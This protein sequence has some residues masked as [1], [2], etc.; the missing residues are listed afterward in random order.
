MWVTRRMRIWSLALLV[1]AAPAPVLKASEGGR[2]KV[3]V[4]VQDVEAIVKAVGGD[5]VD[6]FGLFTGCILRKDLQV[7]PQVRDRLSKADAVIWTGFFNES[8]A[9]YESVKVLDQTQATGRPLWVDVSRGA[10]R[11]HVPSS[12][13]DGYVEVSFMH[14]D[15]F[16]WLNP[17]NGAKIAANAAEGL[18]ELRPGKKDYFLKN[19][20][21]FQK[22][23]ETRIEKWQGEL[24]PLKGLRV[25]STQCGWQNF[26]QIGGPTFI[27][28]KQEPGTLPSTA[29]LVEYVK[30]AGV[31]V[32]LVDPNTPPEYGRAFREGTQAKVVEAPSSIE[33]IQ[34]ATAYFAL[35]ENLLSIL[36]EASKK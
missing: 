30:G 32:I 2:L 35:F 26:S 7:E 25:F 33:K 18:A 9:I 24:K 29:K 1:L 36:K 13:C 31:Q 12:I 16:F 8:A 4:T 22:E 5:Q 11:I 23:L 34:G 14:G 21:A 6:S 19:A 28:C 15:P 17:R 27:V 10:R 20:A 3:A